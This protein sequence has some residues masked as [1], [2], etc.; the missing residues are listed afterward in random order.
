MAT[1]R[2]GC[3]GWHYTGW[4]GRFYDPALPSTRWLEHYASRFDTVELNNSFY[5]LPEA[6]QFA[7]WAASVSPSFTFAVKAS[8]YLT[9]LKRLR[10]PEEPIERLLDR[11]I[12][13]GPTLG[14]ILYQLPPR[15]IPDRERLES[16]LA[17]L[18]RRRRIGR[19]VV[20]LAHVI[21]FRDVRGYTPDIVQ[22]LDRHGVS[23]CVHDMPDSASPR[24]QVG[25]IVYVRFHGFGAK[26]GGSYPTNV[27]EEWSEWLGERLASGVDV[28][29]YF[30]ND[31]DGHAVED[32]TRLVRL[33][34]APA[35]RR[36]KVRAT[37][38]DRS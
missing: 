14:P 9:H 19:R 32:A 21:E 4:R 22:Q 28:Y 7:R 35:R 15:W 24:L 5:R 36:A 25:P 29:V 31:V 12:E 13:L 38:G 30:N 23:L 27:L 11:A 3:S 1:A 17:A 18:P 26:Y 16:F 6:G 37:G 8:R 2:V 10:D 20:R 34:G 33:L